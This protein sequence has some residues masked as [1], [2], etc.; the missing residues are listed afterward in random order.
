[1]RT[2]FQEQYTTAKRIGC[3]GVLYSNSH[4]AAL[5]G[6]KSMIPDTAELLPLITSSAIAENL[7]ANQI[8]YG[9]VAIENS[10]GGIVGET[11]NILDTGD[12][13]IIAKTVLPIHHCLF[14][15]PEAE[16]SEIDT[17]A[18][19][20]QALVYRALSTCQAGSMV[21]RLAIASLSVVQS[22]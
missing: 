12:F 17:I 7:Y 9:V 2:Q 8:D 15:H 14:K 22:G 1:M 5:I 18:S 4:N 6:F 3:Q 11:K 20:I 16:L 10:L 13:E 19:H 21:V